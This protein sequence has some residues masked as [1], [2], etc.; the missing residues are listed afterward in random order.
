ME[1]K[2][3]FLP[4]FF[5]HIY[6]HANG[7]DNLF[8]KKENYLYFLKKFGEYLSPILDTFAYCLMPNHFHFLIKIKP[9]IDLITYFKFKEKY[10]S[11][12]IFQ[13]QTNFQGFED[14]EG[15]DDQEIERLVIQQ[16]SNFF[17]AYAK[18]YN[19]MYS[20]KGAV[21]QT[22]LKRKKVENN[23]YFNTLIHYIHA[24]PVHHGFAKNVYDWKYSSYHAFL[25]EKQTKLEK[26]KVLDWFGGINEFVK[27]HQQFNTS[28]IILEMEF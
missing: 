4:D 22:N 3:P 15:F 20:R 26:Q 23:E 7:D 12:K 18:A 19:K 1:D 9:K 28:Q 5:Y 8:R 13:Y 25:S 6:N 14:L 16:F 10:P 24:N 21:F 27:F 17:N 11:L 2:L